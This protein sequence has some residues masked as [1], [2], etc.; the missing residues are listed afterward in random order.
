M[1]NCYL[2]PGFLASNLTIHATGEL[3]WFNSTK[4]AVAGINPARL[5]ANGIDPFVPGGLALDVQPEGQDPW[6]DVVAH[7]TSQLSMFHYTI[8]MTSWDFRKDIAAVGAGLAATIMANE[9]AS[10]PCTIVGHSAGGLVACIAWDKLVQAGKS[11]LVRRII[12]L[13]T[14]FQGSYLTIA[15]LAGLS[16]SQ[17]QLYGLQGI[18]LAANPFGP[19][20][21]TQFNLNNIVLSWPAFYQLYP[22]LG[23]TDED[24]DPNRQYLYVASN[25]PAVAVPDQGRLDAARLTWQPYLAGPATVPP[26]WIATYVFGTGILTADRIASN[27]APLQITH[28]DSVIDGD[29]TVSHLSAVRAGGYTV[30]VTCEHNSLPLAMAA[31]GHLADLILDVRNPPDPPRPPLVIADAFSQNVTPPPESDY[32]STLQCLGGG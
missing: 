32:V 17:A 23:G 7:L 29:G 16:L 24:G 28:L 4:L 31:N 11:N 26:T 19:N 21:F 30:Q 2:M 8:T 12:T 18:F 14:P 20:Q 10:D 15:W 13:G 1:P 5:A 9:S 6:T 3:F 25:Y 22:A 27:I